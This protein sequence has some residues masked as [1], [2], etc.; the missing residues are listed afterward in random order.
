MSRNS[1]IILLGALVILT[2]FSGLPVAIRSL[3]LVIFGATVL[4]IGLSQRAHEARAKQSAQPVEPAQ[5]AP[6]SD[7]TPPSGISPI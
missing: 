7:A 2:P 5:P 6:A 1:T 3:L 4:G